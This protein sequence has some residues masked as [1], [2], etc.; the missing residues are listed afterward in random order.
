MP[1]NNGIQLEGTV[2][3][4]VSNTKFRVS[5]ANGNQTIAN[6][7]GNLRLEF[8]RILPGDQVLV[9]F[10]PYDLSKGRIIKRVTTEETI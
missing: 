7:A 10:S 6:L 3:E 5:L 2:L 9:E 4:T 1:E 8:T